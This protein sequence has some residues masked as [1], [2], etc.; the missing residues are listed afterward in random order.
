MKK[1]KKSPVKLKVKTNIK[2]GRDR[3]RIRRNARY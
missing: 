3:T 2:A 1:M